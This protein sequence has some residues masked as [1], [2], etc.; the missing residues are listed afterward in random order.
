MVD[1]KRDYIGT[2]TRHYP[3]GETD[4][5]E[6]VG[7]EAFNIDEALEAA[8][9]EF[10]EGIP[11]DYH[12]E[13]TV[14]TVTQATITEQGLKRNCANCEYFDSNNDLDY[15]DEHEEGSAGNCHE[16]GSEDTIYDAEKHMSSLQCCGFKADHMLVE[17]AETYITLTAEDIAGYKKIA[18]EARLMRAQSEE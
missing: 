1:I 8:K 15:E 10:E 13:D 18:E 6:E 5:I 14:V 16:G 12:L 7:V 17:M 9:Y 11:E 4:V 2:L 3:N